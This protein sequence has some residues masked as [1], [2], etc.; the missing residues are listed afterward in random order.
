M[1]G[2]IK[3]TDECS[4]KTYSVCESA[5]DSSSSRV[6]ED[7]ESDG[8]AVFMCGKCKLPIGDSLSWAG[9][10]DEQNQIMLK[11]ITDNVVIGKDPF[12]SG[13]R[14]ELGC[15]VVNLT[16]RGCCSELGIMYIS[17]PK[18]LDYKR[19]LFCFNVE[20]IE[21]YVV[22]SP[23]QRVPELDREDKP[24]TLEYQN[25]VE[26]QMTEIKSLS[27][28]IGQRLLEIENNLQCSSGK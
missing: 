2:K 25:I 16:C 14:K 5:A 19:S 24:V 27:V 4:Y 12:V 17:T 9:S 23:S 21:S 3:L 26:Q 6:E 7:G 8:P 1:A 18:K 11:R 28:I 15:L 20:N 13:T 10:D 22:G